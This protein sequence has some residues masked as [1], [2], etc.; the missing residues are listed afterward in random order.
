MIRESD[1][2]TFVE[3]L[4]IY[5]QSATAQGVLRITIAFLKEFSDG[6]F[7]RELREVSGFRDLQDDDICRP[8]LYELLS[9]KCLDEI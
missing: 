3:L 4:R 1:F 5:C 9:F 2:S 8:I 7:K 6:D